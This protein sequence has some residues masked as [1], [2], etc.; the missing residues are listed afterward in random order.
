MEFFDVTE[1]TVF[2]TPFLPF[3]SVKKLP[4]SRALDESL[5][6]SYVYWEFHLGFSEEHLKLM[7]KH[8]F[9]ILLLKVIYTSLRKK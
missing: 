6:L 7:L 1:L 9:S 3:Q 4:K 8:L 2:P 5:M